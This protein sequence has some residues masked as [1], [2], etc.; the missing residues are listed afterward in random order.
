MTNLLQTPRPAGGFQII[1]ADPPWGFLS[2]SNKRTTPHRTATDHYETMTYEELCVLPVSHMAGKDCVL[3]M[4]TVSS[5][6]DEALALGKRW[7]FNY[8]SIGFIWVKVTT[9]KFP[10]RK[11]HLRDGLDALVELGWYVI[12]PLMGMGFWTRQEAEVCLIF[13]RGKPARISKGVRQVILDVRREHSRKPDET[14][15]RIERLCGQL[16]RLELFARASWAG[17]VAWGNETEKF[18]AAE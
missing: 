1:L 2:H 8:K 14:Y 6:L 9:P 5:H 16:P 17:W 12:R 11:A 18:E 10:R 15:R 13:T 7:G 3:F 4:W